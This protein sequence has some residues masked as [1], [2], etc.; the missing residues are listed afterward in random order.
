MVAGWSIAVALAAFLLTGGVAAQHV[1]AGSKQE[2]APSQ[3]PLN[4]V[5]AQVVKTLDTFNAQAGSQALPKLSRVTFD[6]NVTGTQGSGFSLDILLFKL[7]VSREASTGNE[8]TFTYSVPAS[9]ASTGLMPHAQPATHDFSQSLLSLLQSAAA[10]VKQTQSV[11][12]ARFTDLT[13]TLSYGAVWD[14]SAGG[15]GTLSLVTLDGTVDR[16]RS[17]VQTLTLYFGP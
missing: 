10:Q 3:V 5:A 9:P 15:G 6:F 1:R 8:L 12:S 4:L 2:A 11:G 14:A 13:I 16:K 17:D 7:G